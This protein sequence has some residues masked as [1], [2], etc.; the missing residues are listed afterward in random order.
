MTLYFHHVGQEGSRRDFP[1]TVFKRVPNDVVRKHIPADT[2]LRNTILKQLEGDFPSGSFNCWGVPS[3]ASTVIKKLSRG[4]VVLLVESVRIN[5]E[6]PALCE[7]KLFQPL[8][9]HELS[10]ALWGSAYYPYVFFFD[11]ERLS[12]GWV[13]FLDHIEYKKQFDPRGKFYAVAKNR[14][15][16]FGGPSGYV[17]FLRERYA[18]R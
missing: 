2:P 3:G 11:T 18:I 6:I 10:R 7:V 12:L 17:A 13:E 1:R 16:A 15:A 8:E 9:L 5:G 4:D 14:L